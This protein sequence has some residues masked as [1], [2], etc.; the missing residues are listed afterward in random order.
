MAIPL[1]PLAKLHPTLF[2]YTTAQGL[3]GILKSQTL[4]A[5]HFAYLNDT[6]EFR[7]IRHPLHDLLRPIALASL[8][9]LGNDPASATLIEREGGAEKAADRVVRDTTASMF[10]VLFGTQSIASFAEPYVLSFCTTTGNAQADA[11]GLLSQWRGYG[12]DGGYALVFDTDGI[13]SL[14]AKEGHRWEYDHL[15]G[16]DV[17]YSSA[18]V[19]QFQSEFGAHFDQIGQEIGKWLHSRGTYVM[20]EDVYS[21][22]IQCACRFK[23]WGFAEEKEVRVVALPA[24]GDLAAEKKIHSGVA[25]LKQ[26]QRFQ[27]SGTFIPTIHLFEGTS[28]MAAD[29]LPLTKILVGP[30]PQQESRKKSLLLLLESLGIDI[31]VSVSEI[32]FVGHW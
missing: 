10:D 20:S 29:P 11:H 6:S 25:H 14:V 2:H 24:T 15:T 5:T 4:W 28:A 3:E 23:H 26:R 8:A 30:H 32:P 22:L 19:N 12:R 27:R 17:V 18:S 7:E 21:A 13:D 31:P 16:G 9:T 1:S